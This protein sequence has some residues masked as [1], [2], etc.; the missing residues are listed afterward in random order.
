MIRNWLFTLAVFK[1]E[2]ERSKSR[3]NVADQF[4]DPALFDN[5]AI[6]QHW[7]MKFILKYNFKGWSKSHCRFLF[8]ELWQHYDDCTIFMRICGPY[9]LFRAFTIC[10]SWVENIIFEIE[11]FQ[12][13]LL[14][15]LP[16]WLHW[17]INLR[18]H[19]FAENF[20][21]TKFSLT[22]PIRMK[23]NLN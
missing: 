10:S 8:F 19:I 3:L 2:S 22:F 11:Y 6:S 17:L 23:W 13:T 15:S 18:R 5:L 12:T 20:I 9:A 21:S 14:S 7:P 16:D 4:W 1:I